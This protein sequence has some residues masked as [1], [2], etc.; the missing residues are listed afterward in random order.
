M[1]R[2]L[3]C[4]QQSEIMQSNF[5][6]G[7]K[8]VDSLQFG[9]LVRIVVS[10]QHMNIMPCCGPGG[11]EGIAI[12]AG[13]YANT[14]LEHLLI[15]QDTYSYCMNK[16]SHLLGVHTAQC[17]EHNYSVILLVLK[18]WFVKFIFSVKTNNTTLYF[19]LNESIIY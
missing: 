17:E 16:T 2:H 5:Q 6:S 1:V 12:P 7:I 14:L 19:V 4:P 13:D 18:Q 3:S 9:Y 10:M 15:G 11:L 8:C